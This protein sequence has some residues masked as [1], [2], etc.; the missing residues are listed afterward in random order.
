M[1]FPTHIANEI[2]RLMRDPDA[3]RHE[4]GGMPHSDRHGH[5]DPNQPRVP[6]GQQ[7]GGQWADTGRGSA[8]HER[9]QIEHAVLTGAGLADIAARLPTEKVQ[10]RTNRGRIPNPF[11]VVDALRLGLYND[12]SARNGRNQQAV[13]E[14]RAA[15]YGKAVDIVMVKTLSRSEVGGLCDRF[16][17]VQALTDSAVAAVRN[18]GANLSPQQFGT[19]VHELV[20]KEIDRMKDPYLK[21]EVSFLKGLEAGRGLKDSIRIDGIERVKKRPDTVCIYD[22]KTGIRGLSFPRMFEMVVN[23]QKAYN[24]EIRNFIVTEVRPTQ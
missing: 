9:P 11:E 23:S 1:P 17:D 14:F 21:A 13:I 10:A 16:A 6:A 24:G 5:Y 18:S 7:G 3:L 15:Q 8:V 4:R 19:A 12:L 22:I 20:K 2:A